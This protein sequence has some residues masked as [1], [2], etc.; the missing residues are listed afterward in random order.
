MFRRMDDK[1]KRENSENNIFSS[2]QCENLKRNQNGIVR[3]KKDMNFISDNLYTLSM[4]KLVSIYK[5]LQDKRSMEREIQVLLQ[6]A[7][8][9]TIKE[10]RKKMNE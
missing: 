6:N 2:R 5:L 10:I 3:S 8:A 4:D 9:D 1:L 7:S